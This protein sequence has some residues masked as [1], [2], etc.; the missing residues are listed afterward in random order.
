[1][2]PL[3]A[4]ILAG[5]VIGFVASSVFEP[6]VYRVMS[7]YSHRSFFVTFADEPSEEQLL[8]AV[9]Y[10]E[11]L[12]QQKAELTQEWRRTEAEGNRLRIKVDSSSSILVSPYAPDSDP[13]LVFPT[14]GRV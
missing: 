3:V 7:G 4:A 8:D 11:P 2:K 1:S 14:G 12:I 5:L 10:R 13:D 6:H 9:I